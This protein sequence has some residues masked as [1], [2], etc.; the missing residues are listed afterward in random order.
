MSA[1]LGFLEALL[2][3]ILPGEMES[4]MTRAVCRA[5]NLAAFIR[6]SKALPQLEQQIFEMTFSDDHR[7]TR[8]NETGLPDPNDITVV[9][10]H[11]N[12]TSDQSTLPSSTLGALQKFLNNRGGHYILT[13]TISRGQHETFLHPEVEFIG[14][15]FV[16]GVQYSPSTRS[17]GASHV[18]IQ[19]DDDAESRVPGQ[20]KQI[21]RH[22]RFEGHVKREEIFVAISLLQ[23]L[24]LVDQQTDPYLK[25]RSFGSLW[26]TAFE[27]QVTVFRASQVVCH[28][29]RTWMELPE[30]S[31]ECYHVLPLSRVCIILGFSI[32]QFCPIQLLTF[33]QIKTQFE[34]NHWLRETGG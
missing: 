23:P 31:V 14:A 21:F 24:E 18:I 20:I 19:L 4:A 3:F 7:G 26:S 30:I 33:L 16:G 22:S 2:I 11:P 6:A 27:E 17:M 13:G 12:P 28:F 9:P 1:S 29:G 34:I 32:S 5:S 25:Y 15:L 10:Q 8:V